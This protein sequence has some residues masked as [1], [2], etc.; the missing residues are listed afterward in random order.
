M[1]L[2]LRLL[3]LV[4]PHWFKGVVAVVFLAASSFGDALL[5]QV[6]R[7]AATAAE[8][9]ARSGVVDLHA[10]L[11]YA[12]GYVG[13]SVVLGALSGVQDYFM[14]EV[15]QRLVQALRN[16]LYL[17]LQRLSLSFYEGQKTGELISR[18]MGDVDAVETS[19]LGPVQSLASDATRLGGVLFFCLAMNWRLTLLLIT[20]APPMGIGVYYVG[21]SIRRG[22]TLVREK[23]AE[24][25]SALHDGIAGV[26]VVRGFAQEPREAERFAAATEESVRA[27]LGIA[28]IF[29]VWG[30]AF[31]IITAV[32]MALVVGYGGLQLARGGGHM[33]AGVLLAFVMYTT[34]LYQPMVSLGR[35]YNMIQRALAAADRV[36]ELLDREEEI[37]DAPDAVDLEAA[38]GE[39][40]FRDVTFEYVPG[41]PVL[42]NVS[43]RAQP[44]Q[45]IALV[46]PS[47]AGKSTLANLIPRFYDATEGAVLVDEHDVRL[48]RQRLLR[49]HI[50]IVSQETFL[51][52]G[53]VR[54][55]IAYGR[56]QATEEEIVAA[57]QAANAHDFILELPK[58]YDTEIGER[59]VKLSGGQKQR[60][61]IARAILTDPA[62]LILDEATSSVD[63]EI[64]ILIQKAMD[65]LIQH[66]TTFVIAHRLS[67]VQNADQ[68]L[69]LEQGRIV[70]RGTHAELLAQG[71]LYCKLYETQ[72]RAALIV[73]EEEEAEAVGQ[74]GE[75]QFPDLSAGED[76][77][78]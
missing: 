35:T 28:R 48:L 76:I 33:D 30:P 34:R 11:F 42:G 58:G 53:S 43:L 68:I 72:F 37:V 39:V 31:R 50:G 3:A 75:E 9:M 24:V 13:L 55:N 44:G 54:S 71:G 18:V 10:M 6:V 52:S 64:E 5:P 56:P 8:S 22:F 62:I 73:P 46:G 45:L 26:R 19:V 27:N 60:I 32:G 78:L 66:R 2:Y 25:T 57:A 36:F 17:H 65:R 69:V 74:L 70:E 77:A 1:R 47:G 40:E 49:R 51:F 29:A 20:V 38:R 67:T 7:Y 23:A 61:S 59:G 16:K 63:T 21:R 4:K 41:L 12:L 14:S 15:G